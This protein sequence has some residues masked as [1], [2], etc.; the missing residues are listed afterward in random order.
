MKKVVAI[1]GAG[2]A[3]LNAARAFSKNP[4][5]DVI[6]IDQRNYHLFQPLLYQVATAGLNVSDIA[7][8][9]RTQFADIENVEVHMGKVDFVDLKT[10]TIKSDERDE[11]FKF[12]YLVLACGV[13]HSYFGHNEWEEF[14]PGLKTLEQATEI[15][16]RILSA[17]EHAENEVE[18]EKRKALM[19]FVVV[20]GGPTG[21]EL[22]GAIADISYKVLVRDFKRINPQSSRV[23]LIEAGPRVL[24]TFSENLSL[25]SK[26][27]LEHLGVEVKT[28]TRVINITAEGVQIEN[29]FIHSSTIIWA[30]GIEVTRMKIEPEIRK[31]RVGRIYVEED[32]A[33][34]GFK[35]CFVIGDMAAVTME[36]NKLVPGVAPAAI[37]MGKHVVKVI[38]ADTAQKKR[39]PFIYFDKGS[40][41]TIG[42][43]RAVMQFKRIEASGLIAW[44][45][46]LFIHI[47]YLIG[48][49]NKLSV[50]FQWIWNYLFSKRGA[51]LIIKKEWKKSL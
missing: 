44:V 33:I 32:L 10:K 37:Q 24:S 5:F 29:D 11:T 27:S 45:S 23:I 19:T 14:A 21:V 12:D 4:L 46:W 34:P 13:Q 30:A 7:V 1:I 18:E 39:L 9:I 15:R 16:R 47:L 6:L 8:P 42:R 50:F 41:A 43:M 28:S 17:F 36:K 22:A 51:R 35:D 25:K 3:G 38:E 49:K 2:F 31:D 26:L 48:F 40:M 20:G